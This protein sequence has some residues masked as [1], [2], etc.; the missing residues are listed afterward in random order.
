M[1][2]PDI[3]KE[4]ITYLLELRLC[5]RHYVLWS[6]WLSGMAM[7]SFWLGI[8]VNSPLNDL[9]GG[10]CC[11]ACTRDCSPVILGRQAYHVGLLIR[12]RKP[13]ALSLGSSCPPASLGLPSPGA[14]D[15]LKSFTSVVDNLSQ[16][17]NTP[18]TT[19]SR[20]PVPWTITCYTLPAPNIY[21]MSSFGKRKPRIIQT[22]DDEDGD[23]PTLLGGEEPKKERKLPLRGNYPF[24]PS[25]ET[26]SADTK[27]KEQA[28]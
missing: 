18:A 17:H 21:K 24:I 27:P 26:F 14:L 25:I 10:P 16:Q 28:S 3:S 8:E 13:A 23:L 20:L 5:G 2:K 7:A 1:F 12:Y 22:F 6:C 4:Q 11:S 15:I 19:H 9:E